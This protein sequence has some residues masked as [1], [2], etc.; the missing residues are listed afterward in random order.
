M[1]VNTLRGGWHIG[2][3]D[4]VSGEGVGAPGA[5]GLFSSF[6]DKLKKALK[7]VWRVVKAVVRVVV[8]VVLTG[9]GLLVGLPDLLLGFLTWPQKKL[10]YQIFILS[11]DKGPLV[12][13]ADL[14]PSIDFF[15][16]TFKKRFNVK[17]EAYGKPDIQLIKEPA[18]AAALD[19]RCGTGA[20]VDEFGAAGEF[21][22]Q[23]IAGWNAIP[24]SLGF[25]VTIFIVRSMTDADGCS[26]GPLT[27]HV[28]LTPV[29]VAELNVLAHEVGHSCNLWHSGSKSN[30]M[31]HD[32]SRGDEANWFQ[33]NLLRSSRHVQY[34]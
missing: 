27:D 28:L 4:R 18:P 29:A 32:P 1:E 12:D 34:R 31:W 23:H 17:I 21:F 9:Y 11:D 7:K 6:T 24:I 33:K 15:R 2:S 13:P 19:V 30:L 25:P 10:R 20:F 22:A 3:A 8:R 26:L 16:T 5:M 14:G